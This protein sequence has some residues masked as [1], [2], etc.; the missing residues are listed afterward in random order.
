MR[1]DYKG[2]ERRKIERL[3][4]EEFYDLAREVKKLAL[5]EIYAEI[6]KGVVKR[7]MWLF[8]LGSSGAIAWLTYKG[9]IK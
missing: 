6:G 9:Y 2:Q 4:D 8:G 5:E 3:S 7:V 1:N